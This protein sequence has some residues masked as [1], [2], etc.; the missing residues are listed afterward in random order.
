MASGN[1]AGFSLLKCLPQP[2]LQYHVAVIGVSAFTAGFSSRD[3]R[4]MQDGV[5]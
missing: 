4:S 1:K 2:V 3:F 5:P